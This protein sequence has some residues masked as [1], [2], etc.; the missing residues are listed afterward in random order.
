MAE[1]V[2]LLT[3]QR[4]K[5]SLFGDRGVRIVLVE[6]NMMFTTVG[7]PVTTLRSVLADLSG[8]PAEKIQTTAPGFELMTTR[9]E[10]CEASTN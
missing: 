10:D 3:H 8:S 4:A 9:V 5:A 2:T 7:T 6:E 1:R